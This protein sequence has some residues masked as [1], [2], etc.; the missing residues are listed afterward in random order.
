MLVSFEI[1]DNKELEKLQ[2]KI[3]ANKRETEEENNEWMSDTDK[4]DDYIFE[5]LSALIEIRKKHSHD[6]ENLCEVRDKANI[7]EYQVC[8]DDRD[9]LYMM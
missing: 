6:Y 2:N 4:L 9:E 8:T 3:L 1:I 5:C 7:W